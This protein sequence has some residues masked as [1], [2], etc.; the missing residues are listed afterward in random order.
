MP[1][2]DK[3]SYTTDEM[4]LEDPCSFETIGYPEICVAAFKI[5][6]ASKL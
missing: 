3:A 4:S 2:L 6:F 1:V 5:S